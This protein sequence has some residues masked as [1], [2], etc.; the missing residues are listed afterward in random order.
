MGT[1]FGRGDVLLIVFSWPIGCSIVS[2]R[3]EIHG[4]RNL[5]RPHPLALLRW[6]QLAKEENERAAD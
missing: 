1:S 4:R 2:R 5:L 3:P 6:W